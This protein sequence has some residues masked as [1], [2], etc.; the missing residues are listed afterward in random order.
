M[1]GDA[2][3]EGGQGGLSRTGD[4]M[5]LKP[6]SCR[7]LDFVEELS[8][9]WR[10]AT[11]RERKV[12]LGRTA[13]KLGTVLPSPTGFSLCDVVG[14]QSPPALGS[15]VLNWGFPALDV[16]KAGRLGWLTCSTW[17]GCMTE[18]GRCTLPKEGFMGAW[19]ADSGTGISVSPLAETA[20]G[21]ILTEELI[22]GVAC[23]AVS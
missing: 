12:G 13:L 1:D 22:L 19:A 18:R 20:R 15:F 2:L 21:E 16:T 3:G 8:R 23:P 7:Q 5:E 10:A 14:R 11:S 9:G 6:G 4:G 17:C